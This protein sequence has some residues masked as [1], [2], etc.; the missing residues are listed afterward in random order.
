MVE[1][2]LTNP[3]HQS[4]C[5]PYA[6]SMETLL[7][8]AI[9]LQTSVQL[10]RKFRVGDLTLFKYCFIFETD[11]NLSVRLQNRRNEMLYNTLSAPITA[12]VELTTGC[13]NDCLYCYN[14]WRHDKEVPGANMHR[15]LLDIVLQ[16]LLDNNVFQVTFTGGEVLL[17]KKELFYGLEKLIQGGISCA[18][19]S[20]LTLLTLEDAKKCMLWG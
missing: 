6:R 16:E 9:S 13:D 7:T 18:V 8:C 10:A 3:L 20:N 11:Q 12:Q 2:S 15:D 4:V 14:H 5:V 19:N 1:Q 17:R